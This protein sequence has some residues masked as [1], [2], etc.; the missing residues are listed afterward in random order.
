MERFTTAH[1]DLAAQFTRT[2]AGELPQGLAGL[3]QDV[4]VDPK[5]MATRAASGK[6]LNALSPALPELIGGSADLTPSNQTAIKD[7]GDFTPEAR[8][9]RYLRFGVREHAMGQILNGLALH[10][11][12]IPYGG[13]FW[14]SPITCARL[15]AW[16]PSCTTASS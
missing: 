9:S 10:G 12:L 8:G 6:A 11:G 13:T 3:V 15:S 1:P 5:G 16:R 2:Q 14:C 4:A 7:G